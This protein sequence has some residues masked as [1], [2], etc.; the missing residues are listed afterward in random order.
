MNAIRLRLA[1]HP[2]AGAFIGLGV[3]L[4]FFALAAP[5][6]F[7]SHNAFASILSN[8][9][10]PGIVAIGI[11]LLM[12]SGQFDLSVGSIM[13]VA[14]LVFLYAAVQGL[15]ILLAAALGL[16]AGCGLGL[17][18]GLLLVWTGIPSFIITLGTMLVYRAI[19]L[20][21]ISGGR[22]IR[23]ADFSRQDPQLTI[24]P[25]L[26]LTAAAALLALVLWM[27]W[28]PIGRARGLRRAALLVSTLLAAVPLVSGLVVLHGRLFEPM[29]INFFHLLNGRFD[30][31]LLPGNYRLSI[32]W[33]IALSLLFGLILNRTR[34]G[35][36]VFATGG[37]PLAARSQGIAV[38]RVQVINFVLSGGLAG[39]AGII[40]VARLKS[41]DPLRGTGLE[42]E[43]I[44]A[45]VIGGSLLSGGYGS[46]AG[47][48]AGTT[49]TGVLRTGLVL[50]SVPA[51]A[52][53]GAIGAIM[54]VAVI[55]NSLVRRSK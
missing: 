29:A 40:Q 6:T 51:N 28:G 33:W 7:L 55:I 24:P 14:S 10:V 13:G 48:F 35:N 44:A 21:T 16:A 3:I 23:Y 37:N 42:L 43:V 49:L 53:R 26:V 34:F 38:N 32:V 45:V 36:A 17:L 41:V 19:C 20:T 46:L 22:I 9:A 31:S 27:A 15:H 18:N 25:L 39:S 12:I 5:S 2:E 4:L 1:R 8:Q 52:F 54:I 47:S 30:W 11:T 50:I